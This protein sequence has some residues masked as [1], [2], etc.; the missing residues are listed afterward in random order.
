MFSQVSY[1][2]LC[3][4]D[5][6][7]DFHG[8]VYPLFFLICAGMHLLIYFMH[9]S[10]FLAFLLDQK[11]CESP[12]HLFP[13]MSPVWGLALLVVRSS[14]KILVER[15]ENPLLLNLR[16]CFLR[17]SPDPKHA[18]AHHYASHP[19]TGPALAPTHWPRP[20]SPPSHPRTGPVHSPDHTHWPC[21]L[22][23]CHAHTPMNPLCAL[24]LANPASPKPTAPPLM[25]AP[26]HHGPR[27]L[28]LTQEPH[29]GAG[30]SQPVGCATRVV[31]IMPGAH[32]GE[33]KH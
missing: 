17:G 28:G 1:Y 24:A 13:A 33:Q 21:P 8:G 11:F 12:D 19:R 27:P 32:V 14:L 29:G 4:L 30:G 25:Q 3:H 9:A 31:A 10:L 23:Q 16:G 15:M 18:H 26:P 22:V 5:P 2:F 7:T 20:L 6:I